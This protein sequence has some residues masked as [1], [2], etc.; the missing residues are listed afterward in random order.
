MPENALGRNRSVET[1]D[2]KDVLPMNV[3]DCVLGHIDT[4]RGRE[5]QHGAFDTDDIVPIALPIELCEPDTPVPGNAELRPC[6]AGGCSGTEGKNR[7]FFRRCQWN[8]AIDVLDGIEERGLLELLPFEQGLFLHRAARRFAES[9]GADSVCG[10]Q[11][12]VIEIC[13]IRVAKELERD[14]ASPVI[15]NGIPEYAKES[16]RQRGRENLRPQG[17]RD[18]IQRNSGVVGEIGLCVDEFSDMG[19]NTGL[20][21]EPAGDGGMDVAREIDEDVCRLSHWSSWPP[22]SKF[23]VELLARPHALVG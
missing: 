11:P 20:P 15:R 10:V 4:A 2:Q 19:R 1:L 9:E 14:V 23:I 7:F 18:G 12:E 6:A 22:L 21:V 5:V 16:R 3:L 13:L 8:I 17:Q